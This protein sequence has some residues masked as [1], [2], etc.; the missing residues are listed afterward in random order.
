[1]A[2]VKLTID[3]RQ[4]VADESMTVLEAALANGIYIPHLCYHE[5]LHPQA[6]HRRHEPHSGRPA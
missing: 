3:G 1:M 4:I 6:Q 2:E 5:D